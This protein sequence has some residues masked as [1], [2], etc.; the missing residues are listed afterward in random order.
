[1]KHLGIEEKKLTELGGIHTAREI[2][3]QPEVWMKIYE[4]VKNSASDIQSFMNDAL[5][6]VDDIILTGAG[7]SAYI[8]ETIVNDYKKSTGIM[9]QAI[10]TTDI[11]THPQNFFY[12]N[13]KVLLIS[14]ARSG[15]S[16][17]SVASVDLA[18]KYAG[19]AYQLIITCNIDGALVKNKKA[20]QYSI[21]LPAET[22]D[23]S[24]AMT[25]SFS[26]MLV[27]GLLVSRISTLDEQ[28]TKLGK[29]AQYA[30]KILTDFSP[31]LEKL[32]QVDFSRAI[33]IGSG[34]LFGIGI[35]SH[36]K[37]QELTDG[38]VICK[39]DSYLA[40]RHGPKAVINDTTLVVFLA[41]NSEYVKRYEKDLIKAVQTEN[42]AMMLVSVSENQIDGISLDK[43]FVLSEDGNNIDEEFLALCS[44]L[45]AQIL[46]FFKSINVGLKPDNPSVSGTI[47]RVVEGV[48]IYN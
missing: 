31:E 44:V 25:S 1:M 4:Q 38:K 40:F 22:N 48:T 15:N 29:T 13:R 11:V 17:E 42:Q 6:E 43:D 19:K 41:S 12:K 10:P 2:Q 23:V 33:F 36:L 28:K 30:N 26:G 7:T 5:A 27:T 16:P 21:V 14:F 34:P 18:E 20:N 46:G 9:A 24:L 45:P 3:Q 39:N 8:G 32:A 37:L 35:E 47:A